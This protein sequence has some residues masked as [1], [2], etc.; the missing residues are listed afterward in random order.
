MA[1]LTEGTH[2]G[3]FLISEAN[4][5]RSRDTIVVLT[6]EVLNAGT[7]IG[8]VTASGKNVRYDPVS[9]NGSET[10]AG[11]V[12]G[13]IDATDADANAVII[14]RDSEVNNELLTYSDGADASAITTANT[15]LEALGIIVR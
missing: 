7:I 5:Y 1:V 2:T 13:N 3:E 9:S 8:K 10:V 6:G 4:G 12:F 11:I 14:S 15:E